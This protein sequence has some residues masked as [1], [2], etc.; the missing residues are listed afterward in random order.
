[1]VILLSGAR[2]AY[3]ARRMSLHVMSP[4]T[5]RGIPR[6]PDE[7]T[8][9]AQV[10]AGQPGVSKDALRRLFMLGLVERQVDR[11]CLSEHGRLTLGATQQVR[12]LSVTSSVDHSAL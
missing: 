3:G 6:N 10:A 9:L 12:P 8:A 7:W 11:V 4:F 5:F 1:M 2:G